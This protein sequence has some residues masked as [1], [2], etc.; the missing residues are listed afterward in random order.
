MPGARA[1]THVGRKR[2]RSKSLSQPRTVTKRGRSALYPLRGLSFKSMFPLAKSLRTQVRYAQRGL[3]VNGPAGGLATAH[4]YS[5]N[6]L[7]DPDITGAGHQPIG[8]DQLMA[9]YDHYTVHGAK[10]T[11]DSTN[12]DNTNPYLIGIAVRDDATV[13]TDPSAL[14]ENGN[15]DYRLL[16]PS[17]TGSSM[18]TRITMY[19]DVAKFLGRKSV[20][21]DP[22]CKG[23]SAANPT[24]GVF[25]HIVAWTLGAIDGGNVT[26]QVTIDYDVTFHER[27][28]VAAS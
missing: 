24:E 6:G 28:V 20:L 18:K 13:E 2:P 25:F 9:L 14:V 5:V 15:I 1:R 7:Y 17:G 12:D 4:V 21:S 19:C 23:T 16:T 27:R 22:D 3:S 11:I 10:I 8:F 26:S